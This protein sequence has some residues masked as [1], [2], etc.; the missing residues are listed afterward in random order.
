MGY[1]PFHD[2]YLERTQRLTDEQL[3]RLVRA[4]SRYNQTGEECTDADIGIAFDF[5]RAD[6]DQAKASY[7]KR[8]EVNAVNGAKG[9]RPRKTEENPEKAKK[10][11]GFS[12]SEKSQEKEKKRKEKKA[13]IDMEQMSAFEIAM[14]E[15]RQHRKFIKKPMNELSEKKL[16]NELERL[17]GGDEAKKIAILDQSIRN[18]WQGVFQLKDGYRKQNYEQHP[19]ENL[20]HLLVNLDEG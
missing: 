4:A 12:E 8:C 17:S 18:G 7:K 20:D 6:I 14:E 19:A 3:G 5:F 11:I 9:G 2:S 13:N 1:F 16:L 15:F 10:A